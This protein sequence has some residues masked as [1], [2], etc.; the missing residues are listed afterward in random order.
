MNIRFV[1]LFIIILNGIYDILCAI[2]ILKITNLYPLDT[3]H[4]SMFHKK[5]SLFF[6]SVYLFINGM[7]RIIGVYLKQY[8]IISLSYFIEAGYILY[9]TTQN[10]TV[11]YKAYFVIISSLFLGI[12]IILYSQNQHSVTF[13][14]V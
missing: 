10:N 1:I 12:L 9:E 11:Q 4:L 7:I 5:P 2:S 3:I 6:L 13:P 14:Y 8:F